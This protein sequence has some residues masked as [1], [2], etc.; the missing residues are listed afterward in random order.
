MLPFHSYLLAKYKLLQII[1]KTIINLYENKFYWYHLNK[2]YNKA[3]SISFN[4]LAASLKENT[5]SFWDVQR[6]KH[7]EFPLGEKVNGLILWRA[8][9]WKMLN[10]SFKT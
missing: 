7:D 1:L 8:E 5:M 4:Q 10:K 6:F 3:C 9:H 2:T